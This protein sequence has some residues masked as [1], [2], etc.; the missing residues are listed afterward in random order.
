MSAAAPDPQQRELFLKLATAAEEL[1]GQWQQAAGPSTSAR[2]FSPSLRARVVAA[3]LSCF[4]L[5]GTAL[6]VLIG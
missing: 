1:A 4:E 3:L 6:G 5:V 2:A